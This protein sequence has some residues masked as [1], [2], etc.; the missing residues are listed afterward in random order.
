MKPNFM[1]KFT[2]SY[3]NRTGKNIIENILK[4]NESPL[5]TPPGGSN[6]AFH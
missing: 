3:N 5:P 2:L 1:T 6:G 4:F